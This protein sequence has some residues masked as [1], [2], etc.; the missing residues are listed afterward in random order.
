MASKQP[1]LVSKDSGVASNRDDTSLSVDFP[2]PQQP[3]SFSIHG[4]GA[5]SF[6]TQHTRPEP[7]QRGK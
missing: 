1:D 6:L 2:D 5:A 3:L 7:Q 4:D